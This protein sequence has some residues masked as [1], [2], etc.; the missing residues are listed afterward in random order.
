MEVERGLQAFERL[1]ARSV[2][3][4]DDLEVRVVELQQR[5]YGGDR[6]RLFVVRGNQQAHRHLEIRESAGEV[7]EGFPLLVSPELEEGDDV[8]C[9]VHEID[10]EQVGEPQP[11]KDLG[12][13]SDH[14]HAP[15]SAST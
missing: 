14:G 5:A 15:A 9:Q 7:A 3:D 8:Q 2:V 13:P 12:D 10:T 1:V 6:R 4:D 11:A